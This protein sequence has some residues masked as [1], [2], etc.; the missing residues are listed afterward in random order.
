MEFY[1][2][3]PSLILSSILIWPFPSPR[4][5]SFSFSLS[6]SF[7]FYSLNHSP[8]YAQVPIKF[9]IFPNQIFLYDRHVDFV[10]EASPGFF[11]S[12]FHYNV[13]H[14]RVDH[15]TR[16]ADEERTYLKAS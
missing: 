15:R 7:S 4:F 12:L 1:D 8:S 14:M 6:F 3:K 5:F 16:G 2:S 10:F 11:Y 9:D 13:S